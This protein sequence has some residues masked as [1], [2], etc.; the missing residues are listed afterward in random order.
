MGKIHFKFNLRNLMYR[1]TKDYK[2][3]RAAGVW[4][5]I[6][7]VR[8]TQTADLQ[9]AD[10]RPADLQTCRPAD[11]QT[12]R[13]VRNSRGKGVIDQYLGKGDRGDQWAAEGL[14]LWPCLGQ[15]TF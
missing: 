15:K 11:L 10:R 14:K 13:H 1:L 8:Q 3:Y 9:T 2:P 7:G 12:Y 5:A 4:Q 6:T